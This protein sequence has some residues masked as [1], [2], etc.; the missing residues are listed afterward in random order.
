MG[1]LIVPKQEEWG[2]SSVFW[3][4]FWAHTSVHMLA[5]RLTIQTHWL[6]FR[7]TQVHF[8]ATTWW[9]TVPRDLMPP[10]VD[11]GYWICGYCVHI[12][13]RCICRQTTHRY[14]IKTREN[15]WITGIFYNIENTIG[16]KRSCSQMATQYMVLPVWNV[17]D[18]EDYRWKNQVSRC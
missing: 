5:N 16:N 2:F 4:W 15:N 1:V 18:R 10:Y 14:K 9:F 17:C 11:I 8:P 7:R 3:G 12:M 6:L 13:Y